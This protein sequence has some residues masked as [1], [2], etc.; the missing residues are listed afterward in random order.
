LLQPLQADQGIR[1]V[2]SNAALALALLEKIVQREKCFSHIS[3]VHFEGPRYICGKNISG[4]R[5]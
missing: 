5:R 3:T 1:V 4:V 2:G